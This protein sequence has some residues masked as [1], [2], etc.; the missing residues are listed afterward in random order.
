M[1]GTNSI[2]DQ[3]KIENFEKIKLEWE[4]M[5]EM[6]HDPYFSITEAEVCS[7][8]LNDAWYRIAFQNDV[9]VIFTPGIS[10]WRYTVKSADGIGPTEYFNVPL[11]IANIQNAYIFALWMGV[12]F[13]D[14]CIAVGKLRPVD[15]E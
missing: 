8:P 2:R 12:H 1:H 13:S 7:T 6:F 14:W 5:N 4:R 9:V 11:D 15:M 10:N 3:M